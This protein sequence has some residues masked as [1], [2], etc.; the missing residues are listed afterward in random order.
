MSHPLPDASFSVRPEK[1]AALAGELRALAA[2]LA[3]DADGIRSGAASFAAALGGD[4]GWAAGAAAT[5]WASLH[6]VLAT[7]TDAL[8]GTLAAAAAAYRAEDAALAGPH[9]RPPR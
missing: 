9:G 7:R 1:V 3:D 5:A 2:E 4:E 8:A 6:E